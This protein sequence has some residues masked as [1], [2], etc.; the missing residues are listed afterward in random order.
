MKDN[1]TTQ[2]TFLKKIDQLI[3]WIHG[4]DVKKDTRLN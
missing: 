2:E 4:S 1:K 3:T